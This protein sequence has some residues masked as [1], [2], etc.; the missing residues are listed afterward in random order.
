MVYF[1]V[2]AQSK[3]LQKKNARELGAGR[4]QFNSDVNGFMT[5][6]VNKL[7]DLLPGRKMCFSRTPGW[8]IFRALLICVIKNI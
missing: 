6:L 3:V 2:F 4:G 5:S 1:C 7:P 8:C